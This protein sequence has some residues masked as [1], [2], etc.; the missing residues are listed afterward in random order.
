[1]PGLR[2]QYLSQFDSSSASDSEIRKKV[3]ADLGWKLLQIKMRVSDIG[4]DWGQI[5]VLGTSG[6]AGSYIEGRRT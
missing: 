6:L 3:E 1:M 4:E 5:G 2:L